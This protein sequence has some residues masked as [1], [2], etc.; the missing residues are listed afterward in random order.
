MMS[1]GSEEEA[2]S[3]DRRASQY[4]LDLNGTWKFH[5]SKKP[6]DRPV[7]FYQYDFDSSDWG[8]IPVP[9]NWEVEGHGLP[10]YTNII[11]PFDISEVKAPRDWNPV[12]SYLRTFNLPA[13]WGGRTVYMTFDGVSSAFYLWVNGEKVGYSQGSRTTAE[14]DVTKYLKA[15]ENHV[16]V[17][18]YR[19]SDGAYLEDQDFWRLSGIYRNVYLWSRPNTHLQ[20]FA[21]TSTLSE[22]YRDGIFALEGRV[23]NAQPGMR[24]GAKLLS[25]TGEILIDEDTAS[26]VTFGMGDFVLEDVQPWSSESPTLYD[27]YISVYEPDGEL[28][29]VISKKVG[30]RTVE[31]EGNKILINGV[32]VHFKGVNRHEHDPD[33]GH[34]VTRES[35]LEDIRLMKQNNVNAVRTSHYP[36]APEWYDLCDEYGLYVMDEANIETHEFGN[37][38]NNTLANDPAWMDAHLERV[39]RMVLRDRNHPSIVIWSYGNEAGEGPNFGNITP[40]LRKADPSRLI[41]Y[42]GASRHGVMDYVDIYSRMYPSIPDMPMHLGD[43]DAYPFIACEYTHAMGN[44]NG[45]LKEYWDL[46]YAENNNFAGAFVWDWVDQGL[47]LPVPEAYRKTTDQETFFAYGG[48]WEESRDIH[49][50]GNFCMNGLVASDRVPRPGLKTLKHFHQN[51]EVIAV[52]LEQGIFAIKNRFHFTPLNEKLSGTWQLVRNGKVLTEQGLGRLDIAPGESKEV[53]LDFGDLI[54]RGG[55]Y[56]VNFSFKTIRDTFFAEKGY[57][58][59]WDQLALSG[60]VKPELKAVMAAVPRVK[61]KGRFLKVFGDDFWID[62]DRATGLIN[63]YYFQH[64][65]LIQNGPTMDF[66]RALT[67]NDRGAIK[68][69][70]HEDH[71]E[72]RAE[73]WRDADSMKVTSFVFEEKADRVMVQVEGKLPVVNSTARMQYDIFGDGT[74]D[75]TTSFTPGKG[76]LPILPRL[77]NELVLT[78]GLEYVTWYGPGPDPTY[79]DRNVELVGIYTSTVRD[80]WVEYSRP[81]ENGYHVDTRWMEVRRDCGMGLR[82]EGGSWFGFGIHHYTKS[83]IE[84]SQY[85]FQLTE[86]PESYLNIDFMQMGVGGTNSWSQDAYPLDAY[87]L[88]EGSLEFTYRISPLTG[89]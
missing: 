42:E 87:R 19:W 83:D 45:N 10:I 44:S 46:I 34:A 74:V 49:H 29:E 28:L 67:D 23:K 79:V 13:A 89:N 22:D 56:F 2:S 25:P 62:I 71:S 47:R 78:P 26:R 86:R 36:N 24:I 58:L 41:H 61:T 30:F 60:N 54:E 77:G 73:A 68:N 81:Q 52:N 37:D 15:G 35:M 85:S 70:N 14:F 64:E 48:W 3:F 32:P 18:V 88:P 16:A 40:W 33:R 59:G 43:Y 39:Q 51:V 5:W 21:I 63:A 27:L 20:D 38:R 75:V 50:D 80:F 55:E 17:E 76:I 7:N 69:R 31:I 72:L 53:N 1:Y 6:A 12:G 9:S 11:Y 66:W 57:E 82:I 4:R 84:N 8:T 65:R